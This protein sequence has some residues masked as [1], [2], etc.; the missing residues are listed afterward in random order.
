MNKIKIFSY[1]LRQNLN[2]PLLKNVFFPLTHLFFIE[3]SMERLYKLWQRKKNRN[4]SFTDSLF[5]QKE[6][7]CIINQKVNLMAFFH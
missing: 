1:Y 4:C 6:Y 2:Q 7:S 3:Q 5:K